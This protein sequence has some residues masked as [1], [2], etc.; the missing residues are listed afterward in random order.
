VRLKACVSE[1]EYGDNMKS[2]NMERP[3]AG[4]VIAAAKRGTLIEYLSYALKDLRK[5]DFRA[6]Q[7]LQLTIESLGGVDED[8]TQTH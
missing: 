8:L 7:M 6:Y 3:A 2:V 5:V 4:A 1:V